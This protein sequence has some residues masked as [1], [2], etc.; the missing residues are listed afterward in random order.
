MSG[1]VPTWINFAHSAIS[2]ITLRSALNPLLWF[3]LPMAIFFVWVGL[4]LAHGNV[5][6]VL[7]IFGMVQALFPIAGFVYFAVF[8]PDYLRSENYQIQKDAMGI[9]GAK[10]QLLDVSA[11]H[12]VRIANPEIK[13]DV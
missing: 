6:I 13:E 9:L 3:C 11:E 10:G 2:R 1:P 7:V 12:L 4:T 8:K 5:Q